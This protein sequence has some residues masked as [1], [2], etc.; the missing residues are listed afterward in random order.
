MNLKFIG[1]FSF[2]QREDILP[3]KYQIY[4]EVIID[5]LKPDEFMTPYG[6]FDKPK[7]LS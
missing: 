4:L 3:Q 6:F 2:F 5:T 1:V 7:I